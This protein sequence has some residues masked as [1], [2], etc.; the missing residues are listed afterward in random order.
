MMRSLFVSATGMG[1]QQR[2]IDTVAN[3]LANVDTVGYKKSRNN[4]QDL[5]YQIDRTAGSQSSQNTTVPVGIHSGHGVKHVST[6]KI[7][8]Q[9]D[10]KN[11]RVE[12]DIAI[13]ASASFR[14]FS[15][16]APSPTPAPET[17]SATSKAAW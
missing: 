8:T 17:F 1:A 12:L 15:L 16:T 7:F 4:F 14:S 6:E 5:L 3:N 10:M 2:Q 9:G 11:T 13:E